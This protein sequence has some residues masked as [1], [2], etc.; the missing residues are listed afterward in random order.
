MLLATMSNWITVLFLMSGG[1]YGVVSGCRLGP[2][3]T[4]SVPQRKR[5]KILIVA[6]CL[7]IGR[8]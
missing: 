1:A 5:R 7:L 2:V 3:D 4:L 8:P 6:G